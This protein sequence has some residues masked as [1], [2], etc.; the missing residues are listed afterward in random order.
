[1]FGGVSRKTDRIPFQIAERVRREGRGR[2]G[3]SREGR[4]R[5]GLVASCFALEKK[6]RER[7]I[8]CA[9]LAGRRRG[10]GGGGSNE[11]GDSGVP[12]SVS[13]SSAQ[14]R[15]CASS[16]TIATPQELKVH[17]S[18]GATRETHTTSVISALRPT[19]THTKPREQ[20]CQCAERGLHFP[21]P[22]I[23]MGSYEHTRR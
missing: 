19:K 18:Q 23:C 15:C 20:L 6:A 22:G 9:P 21:A 4:G 12:G 13:L 2:G 14:N 8:R 10:A 11:G 16:L 1:M 7:T 3:R 17:T 5:G